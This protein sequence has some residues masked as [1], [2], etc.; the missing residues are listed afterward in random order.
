MM[1]FGQKLMQTR[2]ERGFSQAHLGKMIGVHA[3]HISR[4]ENGQTIPSVEVLKKIIKALGVSADYLLNDEAGE[5]TPIEIRDK[6]TAEKLK[7]IDELPDKDREMIVHMI[8]AVLT[9]KKMRDLINSDLTVQAE[10]MTFEW[11]DSKNRSNYEKHGIRFEHACELF[12]YPHMTFTDNRF[13]YGEIREISIGRIAK[14]VK[15]T[16]VHT[17]RDENIRIISARKTNAREREKYNDYIKKAS[18]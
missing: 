2:K 3:G 17:T 1:G 4:I 10:R 16:V 13:D 6:T 7:L 15:I 18:G 8:E 9:K 14:D 12:S 5:A 11:D